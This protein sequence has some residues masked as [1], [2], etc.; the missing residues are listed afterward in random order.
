M[1]KHLLV[2]SAFLLCLLPDP[3]HA[4]TL[5]VGQG[6]QYTTIAQA[7]GAARPFDTVYVHPGTYRDKNLKVTRPLTLLG[8]SK[9]IIDGQFGGGSLLTVTSDSVVIRGLGFRNVQLSYVEDNAAVKVVESKHV[10]VSNCVIQ[11]AMFGIYLSKSAH[12]VVTNNQMTANRSKDESNSGNGIHCWTSTNLYISGNTINGHRDGLYFEFARHTY[13]TN[14][15]S[16][17]NI[18]YGLHFMFSDSCTYKH[19]TFMQ[20]GAGIAVMYT[21]NVLMEENLIQDNWGP[22]TYGLL[23]KE[24]SYSHLINN[25]FI[26]NSRAIHCEGSSHNLIENN[27]LSMNGYGFRVLGSSVDNT[28]RGNTFDHNVFDVTTNTSISTNY[29]DRNY[30]SSYQGYDLNKDGIGDVPY[31]PVRLFALM[32]EQMPSSSILINSALVHVLDLTE[33]I[34]PTMTPK[35]LVDKHPL[36]HPPLPQGPQK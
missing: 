27:V 5:H 26:N 24:I 18:R 12:C 17:Q 35:N 31:H 36:M 4:T 29:F 13:I 2:L 8:T 33:R 1:V 19:N 28:L 7:I 15:V 23:L 21:K 10:T 9:A 3:S 22:T 16:K 14:N 11:N 30:W 20:N 34:V 6:K 32:I 25:R